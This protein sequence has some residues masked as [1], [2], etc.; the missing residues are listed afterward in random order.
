MILV[1]LVISWH[2]LLHHHEAIGLLDTDIYS[3][4]MNPNYFGDP[5]ISAL[6]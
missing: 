4:Q 1:N 6:R 5:L 2:F 3:A